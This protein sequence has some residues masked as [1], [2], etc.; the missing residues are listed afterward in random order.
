MQPNCSPFEQL[1]F[2]SDVTKRKTLSFELLQWPAYTQTLCTRC[3]V[4][5]AAKTHAKLVL[6]LVDAATCAPA[7]VVI[8]D[9]AAAVVVAAALLLLLLL[10]SLLWL[11]LQL[12]S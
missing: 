9:T 6:C 7:V 11:L 1:Q 10:L 3:H 2:R 8:V 12:L 5:P 4:E